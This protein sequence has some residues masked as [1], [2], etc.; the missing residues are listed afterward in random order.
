MK[1]IYPA[2]AIATALKVYHALSAE[3]AEAGDPAEWPSVKAIWH[4]AYG[5]ARAE[6]KAAI[7]AAETAAGWDPTP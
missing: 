3:Y 6:F 4:E 7:A 1:T 2:P 5:I